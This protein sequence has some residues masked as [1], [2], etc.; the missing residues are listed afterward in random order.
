MLR[1]LRRPI[2]AV[3]ASGAMPKANPESRGRVI[4]DDTDPAK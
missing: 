4:A 3:A 1:I 2:S